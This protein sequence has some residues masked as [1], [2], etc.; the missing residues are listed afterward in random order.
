M[1]L[2]NRQFL[3][4]KSDH[5]VVSPLF[6]IAAKVV[7][8]NYCTVTPEIEGFLAL[9]ASWP[10]MFIEYWDATELYDSKFYKGWYV[11]DQR[12]II[13]TRGDVC[14]VRIA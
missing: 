10:A 1:V 4:D 11:S 7:D 13:N 14:L 3:R 6:G 8:S 2:G 9:K 5:I 12:A